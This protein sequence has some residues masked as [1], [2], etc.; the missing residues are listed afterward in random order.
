MIICLTFTSATQPRITYTNASVKRLA[1]FPLEVSE[2]ALRR[3]RAFRGREVTVS[4]IPFNGQELEDLW[5][6]WLADDY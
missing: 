1:S 3:M 4:R 2:S 6:R 5:D